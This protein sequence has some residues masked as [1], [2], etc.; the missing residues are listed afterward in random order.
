MTNIRAQDMNDQIQ[1]WL[2]FVDQVEKGM[3]TLTDAFSQ[4]YRDSLKGLINSIKSIAAN[5]SNLN[6]EEQQAR[7]LEL[8]RLG[9]ELKTTAYFV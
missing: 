9:H 4:I 2:E 8:N 7:F 1:F 5:F 6:P 3:S